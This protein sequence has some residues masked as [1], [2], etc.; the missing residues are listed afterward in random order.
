M[1]LFGLEKSDQRKL[2]H[3]YEFEIKS[4]H[5]I[6]LIIYLYKFLDEYGIP[7]KR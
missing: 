6:Y 1:G 7:F 3:C 4:H 5:T 2:Y